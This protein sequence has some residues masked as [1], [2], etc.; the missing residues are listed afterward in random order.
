MTN[1]RKIATFMHISKPGFNNIINVL[2]KK[3]SSL[4]LD[5]L[6]CAGGLKIYYFERTTIR[7]KTGTVSRANYV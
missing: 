3:K 2:S 6:A 7:H 4:T 1:I 5:T